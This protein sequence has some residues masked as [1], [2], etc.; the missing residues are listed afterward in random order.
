MP[1]GVYKRKFRPIK[2]RLEEKVEH[3]GGHWLWTGSTTSNGYGKIGAGEKRGWLLAH[4]VSYEL[5]VGPI[6][7]GL[8]VD[9]LCRVRNCVNPEHLEAVTHAENLRRGAGPPKKRPWSLKTHCKHGHEFTPENTKQEPGGK[10]CLT[11]RRR[12]D[13]ERK[14]RR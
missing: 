12:I 3:R 14:R 4:R 2:D 7:T 8:Q 9:H 1:K 6:P 13:R 11:C 5:F 10:R